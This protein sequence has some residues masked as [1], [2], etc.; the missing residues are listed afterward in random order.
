MAHIDLQ[1]GSKPVMSIDQF[2]QAHEISRQFFNKLNKTGGGPAIIKV[3]R[4]VLISTEAAAAWRARY[5]ISDGALPKS[6]AR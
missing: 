4:R 3:G 5:T 1:S 6:G 2:C